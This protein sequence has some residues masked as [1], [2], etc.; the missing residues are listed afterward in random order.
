M[1]KNIIESFLILFYF[2]WNAFESV[3]YNFFGNRIV[4]MSHYTIRYNGEKLNVEVPSSALTV[5]A[6]ESYQYVDC[7]SK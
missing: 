3:C 4:Q 6:L 5:N 2:A 7:S 1:K